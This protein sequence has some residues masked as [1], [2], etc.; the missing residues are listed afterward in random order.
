MHGWLAEM[1]LRQLIESNIQIWPL[2][3]GESTSSWTLA[4]HGCSVL[5]GFFW[6]QVSWKCG[7]IN[8]TNLRK[9]TLV[10]IPPMRE[11]RLYP[12]M[13]RTEQSLL[14]YDHQEIGCHWAQGLWDAS[15]VVLLPSLEQNI[16]N[17]ALCKE[18]QVA[19]PVVDRL[20]GEISQSEI[21]CHSLCFFLSQTNGLTSSK[22]S[23]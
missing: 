6:T 20:W 8:F 7:S 12:A 16:K 23:W 4:L 15:S 5:L 21:D 3:S 10:L 14:G 2:C 1:V 9:K 11:T 17:L 19:L 13:T 18:E 22:D